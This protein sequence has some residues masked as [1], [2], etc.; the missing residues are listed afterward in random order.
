MINKE[1][2]E[3]N[4]GLSTN[5]LPKKRPNYILLFSLAIGI[6]F[7]GPPTFVIGS[8]IYFAAATGDNDSGWNRI[9]VDASDRVESFSVGQHEV[10]LSVGTY[11]H[12]PAEEIFEVDIDVSSG[13]RQMPTLKHRYPDLG[14]FT[15]SRPGVYRLKDV[16]GDR[17]K[18]FVIRMGSGKDNYRYYYISSKDGEGYQ[19]DKTFRNSQPWVASEPHW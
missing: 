17:Q 11:E 12:I 13:A 9:Y 6:F 2:Q 10:D 18:D 3:A 15:P 8:I 7:L 14:I 19:T 1:E 16:D 4:N 5:E